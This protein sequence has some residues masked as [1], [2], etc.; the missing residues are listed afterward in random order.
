MIFAAIL[1]SVVSGAVIPLESILVGKLFNIFISFNTADQLRPLLVSDLNKTCTED[2]AQQIL[3]NLSKETDEIFCDATKQ[4][5]VINSAS[6][7][8][9]DPHQSLTEK[10]TSHSLYFVYLGVGTF[11]TFFL[12]HALWTISASRQS[13]GL[14]V[15]YYRAILRHKIGWF[16]INNISRLGPEFFK[17]DLAHH[18]LYYIAI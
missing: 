16:E 7:F 1:F 12:S 13:K 2:L 9:C 6:M 11:V 4:G 18:Y 8:I 3:N 15:A 14:R 5:N 10:A 17:Y